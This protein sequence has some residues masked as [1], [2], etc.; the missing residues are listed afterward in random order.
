MWG[1]SGTWN[2]L[3]N[4]RTAPAP[5]NVNSDATNRNSGPGA[6]TT[7]LS[8]R[9]MDVDDVDYV[10]IVPYESYDFPKVREPNIYIVVA[11]G[12]GILSCV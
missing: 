11:F 8:H 5:F 9:N 4:N 7:T 3:F 6:P 10:Q 12:W 2:R 1:R